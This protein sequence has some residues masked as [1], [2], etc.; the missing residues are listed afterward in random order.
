MIYLERPAGTGEAL[1]VL[2]A[3]TNPFNAT[4]GIGTGSTGSG[5]YINGT[6]TAPTGY[7]LPNVPQGTF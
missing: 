3:E 7:S 2:H 1:E 5:L 4:I 6:G